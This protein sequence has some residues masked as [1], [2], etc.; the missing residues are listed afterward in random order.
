MRMRNKNEITAMRDKVAKMGMLRPVQNWPLTREAVQPYT[1]PAR[2]VTQ[3]RI[4]CAV[5]SWALGEDLVADPFECLGWCC[6]RRGNVA[7]EQ[8]RMVCGFGPGMCLSPGNMVQPPGESY[9]DAV[10]K[11]MNWERD[12]KQKWE[13]ANK[14]KK[15]EKKETNHG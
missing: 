12:D 9:G 1:A 11:M 5:L 6:C 13:A 10:V 3:A 8:G 4:V 15:E 14:E 7:D 2:A